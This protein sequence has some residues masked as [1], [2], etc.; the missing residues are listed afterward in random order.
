[1][2]NDTKE[3]T[4][5]WFEY[6]EEIND[7]VWLHL[8]KKSCLRIGRPY[9]KIVGHFAK[10]DLGFPELPT[11]EKIALM[12]Q[13]QNSPEGKVEI[14]A[15]FN[16]P[17]GKVY[18]YF[19]F[20][21]LGHSD[22]PIKPRPRFLIHDQYSVSVSE[23]LKMEEKLKEK[24]QINE[25]LAFE[26]CVLNK[27]IDVSPVLFGVVDLIDD[28][29]KFRIV[30]ANPCLAL[31]LGKTTTQA[32]GRTSDEVEIDDEF[33]RE[34]VKNMLRSR[35][36]GRPHSFEIASQKIGVFSAIAVNISD[37]RYCFLC[38]NI[39]ELK[40][41]TDELKKHKGD[42]E[43]LVKAR[44]IQ[45]EEALEV[46]GRFLAIMSH[47]MR[48]PLTGLSTAITLL[49]ESTL[50]PD[51][52]ELTKIAGVCGDQLM[53]VI[54]DV[55][56]LSKMEEN[57]MTLEKLPVDILK[58]MEDSL[59]IIA[60]EAERKNL[61]LILDVE[62][63]IPQFLI[64]DVVRIRQVLV[65]LLTNAIKFSERGEVHLK[66]TTRFLNDCEC[67]I[68]FSVKDSGIGINEEAKKHLF[69]SFTQAD[70]SITRKY[71]G[72]GL[73]LTITKR[74]AEL[75]GGTIWFESEENVGTT[76]F[77]TLR[78]TTPNSKS[79]C[80]V[81]S[82][83]N[84]AGK[85]VLIVAYNA[86]LLCILEK[87]IIAMGFTCVSS[88]NPQPIEG[89]YD[90]ACIELPSRSKQGEL[91]TYQNFMEALVQSGTSVITI[92]PKYNNIDFPH[93]KKPLKLSSLV[94]SIRRIMNDESLTAPLPIVSPVRNSSIKILIAEDNFINQ[95]VIVKL[96][97][98]FGYN[99]I[100]VVEN[101]QQAVNSV[102]NTCYDVVL[103]DIM[104]PI[105]SGI[106]ATQLIR[107]NIPSIMQPTIIALTANA[108]QE[109]KRKCLECGMN[110]IITKPVNKN[111]LFAFL[112]N[113]RKEATPSLF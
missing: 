55:L 71:G 15:H 73:G 76:F 10:R 72:S 34:L 79:K 19:Q 61:E 97:Q 26:I 85:R 77:V 16:Y 109:D 51:Q 52:Q 46:K 112:G 74:L 63:S 96:L 101:G 35:E 67:E 17:T 102:T 104:M 83:K 14:T 58:V 91:C 5:C 27:I 30:N 13:A 65:N 88:R 82:S 99:N 9:E 49:S 81:N 56:D 36:L 7:V 43:Q 8:T 2:L 64:G 24:Q 80:L 60:L 11:N 108:F 87:H 28:N 93:L 6:H 32:K 98:S 89:S 69:Q 70:S 45:L 105:M 54:N 4:A 48:T 1:M 20:I 23:M 68:L 40:Q 94:S 95:R 113:I 44:T 62:D 92:G 84:Y 22:D 107:K 25:Q 66:A 106:E 39:T 12:K 47:E 33:T 75:M 103:M 50:T 37:N 111:E 41:V 57:K 53:V 18:G 110:A 86:N 3:L 78:T 42:L 100:D 21:F 31:L 29:R 38:I 59:D 90:I